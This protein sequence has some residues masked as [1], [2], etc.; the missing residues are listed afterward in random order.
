MSPYDGAFPAVVYTTSCSQVIRFITRLLVEQ[1]LPDFS[2]RFC[3]G[4]AGPPQMMNP[5]LLSWMWWRPAVVASWPPFPWWLKTGLAPGRWLVVNPGPGLIRMRGG[6]AEGALCY[7]HLLYAICYCLEPTW[8]IH[9]HVHYGLHMIR[10][11]AL[12]DCLFIFSHYRASIQ[13]LCEGNR[14]MLTSH[15]LL[16]S[17]CGGNRWRHSPLGL[18]GIVKVQK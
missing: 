12:V 10:V 9:Q 5:C 1:T 18:G 6:W 4:Q 11:W 14:L 8:Y 2:G 7:L 16:S 3:W 13:G 17:F 15:R